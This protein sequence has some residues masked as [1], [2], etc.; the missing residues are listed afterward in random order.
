M[1]EK[2]KQHRNY[3]QTKKN[4]YI[5]TIGFDRTD[6]P[7]CGSGR[8]LE[9]SATEK[10]RVHCGCSKVISKSERRE[11]DSG[12]FGG[13]LPSYTQHGITDFEGAGAKSR[14]GRGITF[15]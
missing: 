3:Q 11:N 4:P 13:G 6:P 1:E 10:S 7:S 14:Y 15:L 8:L 9:Q 5:M 12:C 2:E